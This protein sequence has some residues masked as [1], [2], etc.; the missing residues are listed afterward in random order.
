M[1]KRAK[2]RLFIVTLVIVI[3]MAI[4]LASIGAGG[5]SETLTVAEAAGGSYSGE[6]VQVSGAVVEDSYTSSDGT[7]TFDIYDAEA[8]DSSVT[9]RVVYSGSVP[10]TFGNGVT[11]ICTGTIGDDGTLEA[12]T[13]VTKCP[14]KYE[15]AEGSLTVSNLL[16]QAD[17]MVGQETKLAGYV[18][19]G[20]L[21]AAG[22]GDRFVLTS[23]DAEIAVLYDDALP[24]GM[25]E[26]SSVVLTGAL[27]EDGEFEATEVAL[28][29]VE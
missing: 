17:T 6:K 19:E 10:A 23:Q 15:S 16:E 5:A 24:S 26:G 18:K 12:T 29:Q 28:E 11:A 3:V 2:K 14:S 7:M 1:N 8:D 21:V 22:E 25:E 27:N 9:L 20:T 13:L 4:I